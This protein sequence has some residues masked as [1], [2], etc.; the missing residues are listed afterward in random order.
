MQGAAAGTTTEVPNAKDLRTDTPGGIQETET[1]NTGAE[2]TAQ[3]ASEAT[4]AEATATGD[5]KTGAETDTERTAETE[6]RAT[7]AIAQRSAAINEG[8]AKQ[9][10]CPTNPMQAKTAIALVNHRYRLAWRE[11]AHHAD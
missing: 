2:R 1:E 3:I 10:T 8:T 11:A 9:V 6:A 5:E 4:K 7:G